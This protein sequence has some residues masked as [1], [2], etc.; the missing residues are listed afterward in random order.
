MLLLLLQPMLLPRPESGVGGGFIL[1]LTG[2]LGG[3][4]FDGVGG[5]D[6]ETEWEVDVP[7]F[8]ACLLRVFSLSFLYVAEFVGLSLRFTP[9][10]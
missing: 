8:S 2:D 3:R 7:R 1:R 9:S 10:K 4:S 6:E 5:A